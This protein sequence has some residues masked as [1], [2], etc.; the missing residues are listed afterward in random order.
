M[1]FVVMTKINNQQWIPTWKIVEDAGSRE[2]LYKEL[3]V[4]SG[5][6]AEIEYGIEGMFLMDILP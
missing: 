5:V 1:G 3:L 6:C 4:V 2:L